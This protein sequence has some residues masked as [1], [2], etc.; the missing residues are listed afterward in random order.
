RL[1]HWIQPGSEPPLNGYPIRDKTTPTASHRAAIAL[2][3]RHWSKLARTFSLWRLEKA[4]CRSRI[5]R[6]HWTGTRSTFRRERTVLPA[7]RLWSGQLGTSFGRQ[8][9]SPKDR[10]SF[11]DP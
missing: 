2:D 4:E 10:G 9:T 11:R 6:Y 3:R 1:D 5:D 7:L 8:T